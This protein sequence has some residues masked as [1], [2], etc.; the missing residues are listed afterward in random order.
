VLGC[1]V[2]SC[3]AAILEMPRL[4]GSGASIVSPWRKEEELRPVLS[5]LHLVAMPS[6][7]VREL[8]SRLGAII[9]KWMSELSVVPSAVASEI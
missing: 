1:D 9:A 7:T 5:D 8:H 2:A 4:M 6:A 3:D